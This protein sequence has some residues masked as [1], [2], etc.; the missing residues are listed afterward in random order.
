[1][2]NANTKR[3]ISDS[4]LTVNNYILV[5]GNIEFSRLLKKIEGD[6]LIKDQRRKM[7]M[8]MNP[9]D[10]PY[11]TIQLTNARIV[12]LKPGQKSIEE[13]FVEERFYKKTNDPTDTAYHYSIIN[14]SPFPNLFYQAVD[15]KTTEGNQIYPEAELANGLDVILVLR[16]FQAANFGRKSITLHSVI[17]QEP[18]R[19]YVA[20]N[21]K[22]LEDAGIILHNTEAPTA[23]PQAPVAAPAPGEAFATNAPVQK[24]MPQPEGPWTC[25][26]CG[27]LVPAGQL[28]CGACGTK[29]DEVATDNVG[30]PYA[31]PNQPTQGGIRYN[32]NDNIRN[33]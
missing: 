13:T 3:T 33:Y 21:T 11:T 32:A 23:Q 8:G 15:G 12:P 27:T 6:E 28:F 24:E 20:A 4:Q 1:M 16:V 14:K 31:N 19:Y 25:P 9:I 17:I 22:A 7:Q 18:V 2:P 26:H 10:K 30:N 5:R 29:K